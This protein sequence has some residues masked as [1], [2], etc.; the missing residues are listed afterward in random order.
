VASLAQSVEEG[1]GQSV[2][3]LKDRNAEALEDPN[4]VASS[5]LNVKA[6]SQRK[7]VYYRSW[8]LEGHS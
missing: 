7:R 6:L 4:G 3:A 8:K 5:G 1:V 2:E